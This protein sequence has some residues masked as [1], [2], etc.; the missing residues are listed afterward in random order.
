MKSVGPRTTLV[1]GIG[2]VL[3]T[4]EGVG[5]HVLRYLARHHAGLPGVEYLDGGTLNFLLTPR[6]ERAERLIV[7]DASNLGVP[8]GTY[9]ILQNGDMDRFLQRAGRSA[10][11]VSLLDLLAMAR[12]LGRLPAP[13]AL[14]A[15]QPASLDWGD[16]PSPAL[17]LAIS[18]IA[19]AVVRL[20]EAWN[21]IAPP[22]D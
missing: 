6:I 10:H 16:G 9:R 5:I 2:N 21:G 1:L 19:G 13:R 17:T 8:P 7:I 4:D 18:S 14:V 20:L 12:W 11:E 22:L 3:L 15:V